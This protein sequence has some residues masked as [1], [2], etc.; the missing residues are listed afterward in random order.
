MPRASRLRRAAVDICNRFC[1]TRPCG[2]AC[3]GY[4][5]PP[6]WMPT[7]R[8]RTHSAAPRPSV[9]ASPSDL[10]VFFLRHSSLRF[11]S[12]FVLVVIEE[13]VETEQTTDQRALDAFL[14]GLVAAR[15]PRVRHSRTTA[16]RAAPPMKLRR[17]FFLIWLMATFRDTD[18]YCFT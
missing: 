17:V 5:K 6:D 3:S 1:A 14:R 4:D 12:I 11:K 10:C 13:A 9:S 16:Q 8:D 15:R 2:A 18:L 7:G